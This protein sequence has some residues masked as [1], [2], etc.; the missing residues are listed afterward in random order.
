[1]KR[2][3]WVMNRRFLE[4]QLL[5]PGETSENRLINESLWLAEEY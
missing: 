1:M 3:F 4:D 5:D 2:I